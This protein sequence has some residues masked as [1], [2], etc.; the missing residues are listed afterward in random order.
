M[1][2]IKIIKLIDELKDKFGNHFIPYGTSD[3][4]ENGVGFTIKG[5]NAIFSCITLEDDEPLVYDVQIESNP[6]GEY[7]Y[8]EKLC[9]NEII[10][11]VDKYKQPMDMW[12]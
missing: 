6:P 3:E 5:I 4:E 10:G 1:R 11:I 7:I 8:T 2:N 9:L 12:P